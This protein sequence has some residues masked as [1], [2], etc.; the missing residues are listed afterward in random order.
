MFRSNSV[1]KRT[2]Y[3]NTHS[4]TETERPQTAT[5]R[6]SKKKR[7]N[8]TKWTSDEGGEEIGG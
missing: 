7:E 4:H 3:T 8:E 5:L 1:W 2:V 6:E